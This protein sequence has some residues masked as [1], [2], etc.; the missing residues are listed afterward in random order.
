MSTLNFQSEELI[1]RYNDEKVYVIDVSQSVEQDHPRSLDFLR[2]DIKNIT[3]FFHKRGATLSESTAFDFITKD[4]LPTARDEMPSILEKMLLEEDTKTEEDKV[5]EQVFRQAYIPRSLFDVVDPER[6]VG[7]L[8]S[9]GKDELIYAKFLDVQDLKSAITEDSQTSKAQ[10]DES[11]ES[12]SDIEDSS[13]G[14]DSDDAENPTKPRG[15]RHED[16]D[17][18]KVFLTF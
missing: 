15:K 12:D 6:D 1:N 10:D 11:E 9:G 17:A 4:S 13:V 14:E 2:M 8:S 16:K 3:D 18:K 7:I 5:D